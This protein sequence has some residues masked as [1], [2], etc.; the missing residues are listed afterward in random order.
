MDPRDKPAGDGEGCARP[1]FLVTLPI[2]VPDPQDIKRVGVWDRCGAVGKE[3]EHSGAARTMT[4]AKPT[5]G[6]RI[7]QDMLQEALSQSPMAMNMVHL[8][9]ARISFEIMR[10]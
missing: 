8:C 6:T 10:G 9:D 5:V 4:Q 3:A 7:I 2:G 1:L